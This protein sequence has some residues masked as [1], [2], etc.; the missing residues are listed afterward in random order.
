MTIDFRSA[1]PSTRFGRS[2]RRNSRIWFAGLAAC[3]FSGAV[4][5]QT[6]VPTD[7]KAADPTCTVTPAE[8]NSWF[9]ALPVTANGVAKSANSLTF[10]DQ[11]NCSFYKWAEQM[12]LWLTSPSPP[13]G[14]GGSHVF[15][16]PGFFDVSPLDPVTRTRTF[17]PI[18]PGQPRVLGASIAQLGPRNQPV[19][20]DQAGKR[21]NIVRP[22]VSPDGFSQIRNK[23]GQEVDIAR[24]EVAPGGKPVFLDK[25]GKAIE[26]RTTKNGGP[27]LI[28]R[29]GK[30][31]DFGRAT[32]T[33][34]GQTFFLNA[35]G[36]LI[37]TDVGQA[38]RN[39]LMSQNKSLVYYSIQVNDV[40]AYFLSGQKK[41][42]ISATKFPVNSADLA[43]ITQFAASHN[44]FFADP[45]ALAL[46][47]KS[48]WVETSTLPPGEAGKYIT[49]K[50]TVPKFIETSKTLWTADGTKEG[51]NLPW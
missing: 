5:A 4:E 8:F 47:L 16:S 17:S 1:N 7:A 41:G 20:F 26:Y 39:V 32:K 35:A 13:A 15:V 11:P 31:I 36:D 28:D 24:T 27:L 25:A 44:K 2:R 42:P 22:Q 14:G 33:I 10:P 50:A 38:D 19:L 18:V 3:C 9:A 48:S 6:V 51:R 43:A 21:F 40:F 34:N 37:D 12:F 30:Q 49:I 29:S 45:N 46:E 23:A